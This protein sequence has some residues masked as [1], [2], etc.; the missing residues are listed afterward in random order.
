MEKQRYILEEAIELTDKEIF[1]D[2]NV[3]LYDLKCYDGHATGE[4]VDK[5]DS[6]PK[7]IMVTYPKLEDVIK[8]K[9]A[10]I[11]VLQYRGLYDRDD[12]DIHYGDVMMSYGVISSVIYK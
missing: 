9:D 11:Y 10:C 2:D 12:K 1:K 5:T 7:K 6:A 8:D 3:H 4:L